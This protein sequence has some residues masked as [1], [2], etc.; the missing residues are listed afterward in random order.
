[1]FSQHSKATI[2]IVGLLAFLIAM[3]V[4]MNESVRAYSTSPNPTYDKVYVCKYVGTPGDNERLQSGQNPVSV[5]VNALP[6]NTGLGSFFADQHGRS[7]VVAWDNG[8]KVEPPVSLCPGQDETEVVPVPTV[9]GVND[10]CGPTNAT[11]VLPEDTEAVSWEL[12]EMGVLMAYA[13]EGYMFAD[14]STSYSFGAAVDA[15]VACPVT[16]PEGG[17]GG[18][19]LGD[20]TS[21]S[22][23]QLENTGVGTYVSSVLSLTVIV[24][25]CAALVQD[26]KWAA[27]MSSQVRSIA[28]QPFVIPTA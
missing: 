12:D 16:P 2:K 10:P 22:A 11:W 7:Y 13:N 5:S 26:S 19:V 6:V 4:T 9:P 25:A 23:P 28:G 3:P 14:E 27:K 8:D 24:L 18:V 20:S 1:M 17:R 21:I 15:N